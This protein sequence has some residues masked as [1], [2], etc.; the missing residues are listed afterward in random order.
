MIES[1]SEELLVKFRRAEF[2]AF[3]NDGTLLNSQEFSYDA[4]VK[5]WKVLEKK[6][7]FDFSMPT[8]QNF[9]NLIGLPWYEFFVKLLPAKYHNLAQE[10]HSEI[11]KHELHALDIGMGRL[12]PGIIE[13]LTVLKR[14]GYPMI[15][16]SNA[17][18]E[19]FQACV[20]NLNYDEHFAG[21]YCV[22]E[23]RL[24]KGEILQKAMRKHGFKRGVIIG[25]RKND[26]DAGKFNG[27]L[28]IGVTYGYGESAE[29]A[30]ADLILSNP[31]DIIY[32]F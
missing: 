13:M 12:F 21:C 22:G 23:S 3:D 31:D 30:G 14:R 24:N 11:A 20:K 28:T 32:V 17:S 9:L 16:T 10:L 2:I 15:V 5:A 6:F 27:L 7:N 18:N 8:L 29:L 26:I 19:Y 1:V 25:D 4:F